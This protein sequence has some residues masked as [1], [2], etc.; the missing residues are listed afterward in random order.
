MHLDWLIRLVQ[1]VLFLNW[2]L[3]QPHWEFLIKNNNHN[4]I[5]GTDFYIDNLYE[6]KRLIRVIYFYYIFID[7][8]NKDY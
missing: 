8:I 7:N 6:F 3:Q 5:I 2:N 4:M 1:V